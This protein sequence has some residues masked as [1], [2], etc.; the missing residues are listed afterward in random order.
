[1]N[2]QPHQQRVIDEYAELIA[3]CDKLHAFIFSSKYSELS[4]IEQYLL[5][6]QYD[7]MIAYC[8]ALALRLSLWGIP[9]E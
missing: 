5:R 1:M 4:N 7:T 8:G 2:L 3:R 9:T 6:K